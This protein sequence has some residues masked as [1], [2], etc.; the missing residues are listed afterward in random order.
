[1]ALER[2]RLPG[3]EVVTFKDVAVDFTWEEWCLLSP[4][5]KLLYK[6]VMLE[7]T[8]TLLSVGLPAPPEDMISYL[9]QRE[10][11]WMLDQEDLRRCYPEGKLTPKLKMNPTE[12]SLPVEEMDL[13]RFM[14]DGPGLPA[15][16]EDMITYLEQREAP[17]MLDQEDLRRSYPE[18]ELRPQMKMNPAEESLPIE[19]MDLRRSMSDGHGNVDFREFSVVPQNSSHIEHQR[20]HTEE[21]SINEE[22]SVTQI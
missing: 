14:S 15:P 17:W 9:E 13:Q 21:K 4:P 10:A 6:E 20:M 19:E 8:R 7:N 2:D 1:M 3:Q 11:P 5:Q 22:V 16:P 18:G 12:M